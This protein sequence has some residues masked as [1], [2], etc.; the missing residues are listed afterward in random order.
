[1]LLMQMFGKRHA[2]RETVRRGGD[3]FCRFMGGFLV[4]FKAVEILVSFGAFL[5]TV[6]LPFDDG[7]AE[8]GVQGQRGTG[9]C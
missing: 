3:F 1:V 5:A 6:L 9:R 7:A 4:I 8:S 2:S